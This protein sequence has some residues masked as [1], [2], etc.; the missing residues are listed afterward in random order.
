MS[1]QQPLCPRLSLRYFLHKFGLGRRWYFVW[2]K[3][4]ADGSIYHSPFSWERL[5]FAWGLA[6]VRNDGKGCACLRES[7][8]RSM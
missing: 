5:R 2:L 3:M 4:D 7:E 1:K 6:Y 8:N